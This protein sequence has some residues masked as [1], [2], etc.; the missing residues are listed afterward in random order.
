MNRDIWEFL[1]SGRHRVI[2]RWLDAEKLSPRD[3][4]KLDVELEMLRTLDFGLVSK[5]L[6]AGPLRGSGKL[7][8]LR[9]RC[10]NREL[11]PML[12]R[13]PVGPPLDYTLLEGAIEKGGR[14]LPGNAV[15]RADDNRESLMRNPRWREVY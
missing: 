10:E 13:G 5:K 4:A 1:A 11:R 3:R 7:F 2:R 12:C 6:L 14:L 15:E 8:K 9:V